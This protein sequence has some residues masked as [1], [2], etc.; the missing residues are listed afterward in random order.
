M[1]GNSKKKK[2]R[3]KNI[4]L[5]ALYI[6]LA[7]I[8]VFPL[9][10]M[11]VSSF[12]NDNQIVKDMSSLYAFLPCG[13]LS[14]QNYKDVLLKLDFLKYFCNSTVVS[15]SAVILG[16]LIN[17]MVGYTLGMM[18]FRGKKLMFSLVLA[19]MIVPN[20]AIIIN[21]FMVIN[22]LGLVNTWAGLALPYLVSPMYIYM[23]YNHFRGMPYELVDAAI[24]DGESYIGIFW[25]IMLPLS[26]PICATVAIMT[27]IY[28]WGDLLWP[29]MVTRDTSLRTLP[30]ALR[31]LFIN[32]QTLWG[33][34]F[35][36]GVLATIPI[37][38]IFIFFQKEFV[39]S[40]TS[41]GIK[42]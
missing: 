1:I 26:K 41:S 38:L 21:R 37:L 3:V 24:V 40:L 7:L 28:T 34:V 6:I 18:K 33:Q 20:E 10:Y 5:Y 32:E 25:K 9:V 22:Q 27:F 16:T 17:G 11:I 35:A 8:F 23:F 42:G 29:S 4:L 19:F 15:V 30:L 2:Q 13:E 14:L 31:S 12:K 36:F 39:E